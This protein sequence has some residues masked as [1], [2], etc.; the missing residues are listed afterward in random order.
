MILTLMIIFNILLLLMHGVT[1]Q[2]EED[3]LDETVFPK[4]IN[5]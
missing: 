3:I 4:F 5:I 2:E 1:F